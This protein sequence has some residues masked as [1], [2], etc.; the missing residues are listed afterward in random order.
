MQ[1]NVVMLHCQAQL[2]GVPQRT[3]STAMQAQAI[4]LRCGDDSQEG[5]TRSIFI[6]IL[7]RKS[8]E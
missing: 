8:F 5:K 4:Q 6:F 7:A 2:L 1:R 3:Q